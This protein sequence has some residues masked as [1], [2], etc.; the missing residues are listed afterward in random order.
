MQKQQIELCEY[1]G[2]QIDIDLKGCNAK[3]ELSHGGGVYYEHL[4]FMDNI[5]NKRSPLTDINVAKWS[6]LVG[7]AAEESAR[8][9]NRPVTF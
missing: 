6:V 9:G 8:N 5:R 1:D 4:A 2:T 3:E 7:L